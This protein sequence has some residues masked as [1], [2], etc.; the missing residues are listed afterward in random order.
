MGGCTTQMTSELDSA[1]TDVRVLVVDDQEAF[2]RAAGALLDAM[3]GFVLVGDAGSGAEGLQR[4]DELC[5]DMVLMDVYMP[6]MDGFEAV[7]RLSE[8]HPRCVAVLVS[9]EDVEDLPALETSGGAVALLRKQDL[10]PPVLRG[11]WASHGRG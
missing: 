4:A 11:L 1:E 5:P 2:R 3:P 6:E 9:L 8:A 10:K 7:R